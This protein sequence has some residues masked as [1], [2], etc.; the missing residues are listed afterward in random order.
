MRQ[1]TVTADG[2]TLPEPADVGDFYERHHH[3]LTGMCGGDMHSGYWHGPHDISGFEVASARMTDQVLDRLDVG[4]GMKVLDVG[5]GAGGPGVRLAKWCE[6]RVTGIS[7]GAGEVARATARAEAAGVSGRVAFQ[8]ADAAR[9]P[10]PDAAFDRVMAIEC[11]VHAADR[12]AVLR[13]IAR[14]LKPGGRAVLTDFVLLGPETEDEEEKAAVARMLT[15]LR[16]APMVRTEDYPGLLRDAGLEPVEITDITEHT[17]YTRGRLCLAIGAH[18]REHPRPS[19]ELRLLHDM[20]EHIEWMDFDQLPQS[21]G[22]VI[23]VAEV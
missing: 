9:M 1:E 15:A 10:F 7:L 4:P 13:E 17:K 21:D 16:T 6:A 2:P 22:V 18:L 23:V 8:R 11:L 20:H 3:L 12:V 5:C 19:E 14:V